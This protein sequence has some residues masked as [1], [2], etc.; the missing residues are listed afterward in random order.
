VE[1]F[2]NGKSVGKKDMPRNKHLEWNIPYEPGTL[3]AV[4]FKEGRKITTKVETTDAPFEIVVTPY[5]T[6]MLADGT[7]ANVINITVVDKQGREVPDADNLIHFSIKGDMKIIGVGNGDPSS[8]EPDKCADGAWQRH[9]F[10]GK[11][12]VIVQSGHHNDI[13]KF[14][15][16]ADGLLPGSADFH[17]VQPGEPHKVSAASYPVK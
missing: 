16:T 2:L 13:V 1:L 3:E 4:A 14:E 9:L 5:K 10:N 8:H 7:D 6:S 11:C 12:Q 15:A 17:T